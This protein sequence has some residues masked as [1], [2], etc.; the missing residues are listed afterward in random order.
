MTFDPNAVVERSSVRFTMHLPEGSHRVAISAE[1]LVEFYGADMDSASL[2]DSYR[3][4]FRTIHAVAQQLATRTSD[5]DVLVTGADLA[6]A[7][8]TLPDR[9]PQ[10]NLTRRAK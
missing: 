6:T 2:L 3:A 9:E 1:A 8:G 7:G 10:D 4:N 5:N